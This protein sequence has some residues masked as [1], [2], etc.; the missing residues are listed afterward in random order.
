M[1]D[2][3]TITIAHEATIPVADEVYVTIVMDKDEATTS[4]RCKDEGIGGVGRGRDP[5]IKERLYAE[6][7]KEEGKDE[8]AQPRPITRSGYYILCHSF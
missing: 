5:Y 7:I 4:T 1:D 3:A 6:G 2:E 8:A